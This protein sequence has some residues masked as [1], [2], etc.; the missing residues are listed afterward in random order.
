[1]ELSHKAKLALTKAVSL[2]EEELKTYG[3]VTFTSSQQT[4]KYCQA[5]LVGE[6]N[7]QFL[8]LFLDNQH[9]LIASEVLFHGTI[10]AATIYPRVVM[11]KSLAHGAAA[12]I[13]SHNH[14]S[15]GAEAS[16][17]DKQITEKLVKALGYVDIRVLD[18]IIVAGSD[19]VSLAERGDM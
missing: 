5:K 13:L 10:N 4:K 7:E 3:S 14:P 1:M 15:G 2:V 19:T 17:A 18:H 11:E 9:N 8:V 6:N 16:L 12:L